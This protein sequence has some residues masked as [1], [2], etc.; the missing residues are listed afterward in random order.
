MVQSKPED[1]ATG[2]EIRRQGKVAVVFGATG[3]VGQF[4]LRRLLGHQAYRQVISIGRRPVHLVHP[5]LTQ[6]TADLRH[7]DEYREFMQGDDLFIAL[8]TTIKKAGSKNAFRAVDYDLICAVAKA[9]ALQN[10]HQLIL[11]SSVGADP[12]ASFFYLRVKGEVEEA[13]SQLPFWAVH[14]MR[15]GLLLGPREDMRLGER[16]AG[17]LGKG[18]LR[19]FGRRLG[20]L[21]PVEA[22]SVAAAMVAVAQLCQS[23]IYIHAG[24]EIDA[25]S[26]PTHT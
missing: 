19:I 16:W 22:D 14:I 4:C 6:F 8:G 13:V 5:R 24:R 21:A 18:L 1:A 10:F 20:V 26:K 15:P 11:V 3:L 9:G 17:W 23:G 2:R 25:L 12:R 7:V